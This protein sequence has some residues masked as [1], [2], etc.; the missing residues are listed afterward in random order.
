MCRIEAESGAYPHS[1]AARGAASLPGGTQMLTTCAPT[2]YADVSCEIHLRDGEAGTL[3]RHA[4][5]SREASGVQRRRFAAADAGGRAGSAS[6]PARSESMRTQVRL[7]VL[8]RERR[9]CRQSTWWSPARRTHGH[10]SPPDLMGRRSSA[11]ARSWRTEPPG[12][13]DATFL[14]CANPIAERAYTASRG[15][16]R[17]SHLSLP[18]PPS[19]RV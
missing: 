12:A 6:M 16:S 15:L 17:T 1:A 5:T 13:G 9:G 3:A 11:S 18:L 2:R 8:T 14:P 4:S 7:G 10:V 19:P